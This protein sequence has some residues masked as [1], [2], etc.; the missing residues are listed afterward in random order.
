MTNQF[1]SSNKFVGYQGFTFDD[2][3]LVPGY[4]EVMP[5]TVS[6]STYLTRR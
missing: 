4:S 6:V 5:A 1:S 2:V 3:L